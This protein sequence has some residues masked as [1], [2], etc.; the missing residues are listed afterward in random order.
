MPKATHA[1][2][3]S[4]VRKLTEIINVGPAIAEDFCLLE[5]K[6]PQ[7]LI[8]ADPVAVYQRLNHETKTFHDP[9]VLDVFLAAIDFMNGNPPQVWWEYT[10]Q[11]KANYSTEVDELR[12]TYSRAS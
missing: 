2:P 1:T 8:G 9:C 6:S 7:D 4:E 10:E 11:R 5:M 12:S 3:R